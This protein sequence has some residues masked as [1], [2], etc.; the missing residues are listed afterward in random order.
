MQPLFEKVYQNQALTRDEMKQ[1]ATAIFDEELTDAQISAFLVAL[2]FKGITSD[3]LTGL[4]E[5][6]QTRART[7]PQTSLHLMDNCGTGGDHSNSF[8]ISTTSAFVLAGGGI[9][10][11]K[12]GN[13]SVSSHSGSA[14]VLELLGVTLQATPE[15]VNYLLQEAGIAFLFAPAFHPAMKAVMPIRKQLATPT[16]F[17]L[18]GPIINPYPLHTQLMGTFAKDT[19]VETAETLGKLGRKRAVVVQ[20][21]GGMDEANLTGTTH[22]T[23]YADGHVTTHAFTPE[24]VGLTPAPLAAIQSNSVEQNKEI[25]LSVLQGQSSVY[26]DT[27]CLNAGLGFFAN[28]A[29][30]DMKEGIRLAK[31]VIASGAAYAALQALITRQKELN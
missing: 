15:E 31:E 11:A 4:A 25:L 22:F 26:Y 3:E 9:P 17:N 21:S 1:V 19:L 8:N 30:P 27:V 18:I 24:E 5:V 14:D 16:I 23:L 6:M 29:V 28:G 10:M 13:R 2:K 12:H 7:M 20:G